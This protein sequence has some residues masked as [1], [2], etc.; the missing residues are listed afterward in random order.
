MRKYLFILLALALSCTE[1]QI[2]NDAQMQP[3]PLELCVM[4]EKAT[5]GEEVILQWNGFSDTASILLRSASGDEC[6]VEIKV[7]TESGLIFLLPLSLSPGTYDVVLMQDGTAVIGQLEVMA[8]DVPVTGLSVPASSVAGETV[9]I[10]GLGFVQNSGIVLVSSDGTEY[11]VKVIHSASGLNVVIPEDLPEGEYQIRLVQDGYGWV[12]SDSFR[13][14]SAARDL[15]SVAYQG[16]Y[17]GSAQVRY[18]WTVSYDPLLRIVL[19]E[20][21]IDADGTVEAGATDEYVSMASENAF[22]LAADGFESSNDIEIIYNMDPEGGVASAD[23]LIYGKSSMTNFVW[24][25]DQDGFLTDVTYESK[26][27]LRT[28]ADFAYEDGNLIRFKNASFG[29]TDPSLKNHPDAPDVV[30]GYMA[31]SEK[32]DPFLYFPYLLG[33]YDARSKCLPTSMTIAEGTGTKTIPLEYVFDEK[34]YV[35]EM[36]WND[37][38]EAMVIFTF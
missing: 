32:F 28:F 9:L 16:P 5:C 27:G 26:T 36:K 29:Y 15:V 37:K 10:K 22:E 11:D 25:Y 23:V 18:T 30:W 14:A 13:V 31:V 21:L 38:G 35:T 24:A 2:G 8:P 17:L 7:I 6:I 19:S 34:G 3:D 1:S 4:P 12:I 33:W 20:T